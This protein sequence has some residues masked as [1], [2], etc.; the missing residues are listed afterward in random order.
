MNGADLKKSGH[1]IT[2][3]HPALSMWMILKDNE[4][5][6]KNHLFKNSWQ[7]KGNNEPETRG[8]MDILI[9]SI[10]YTDLVRDVLN[11]KV[12]IKTDDEL[13]AFVCWL[14]G[15][16]LSIKSDKVKIYG[17]HLNGSF[18]LPFDEE[19]LLSLNICLSK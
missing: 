16:Y 19:I 3:I 7:Y 5:I 8:R 14:M 18:L 11:T 6:K 17:D 4:E 13:D 12:E 10:L 1:F 9:K 2:E 15:K